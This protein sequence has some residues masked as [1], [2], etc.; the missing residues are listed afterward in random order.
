MAASW[1]EHLDLQQ[2]LTDR[3]RQLALPFFQVILLCP[4]LLHYHRVSLVDI[5][6]SSYSFIE[7]NTCA[8]HQKAKLAGTGWMG[9]PLLWHAC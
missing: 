9:R 7:S 6:K 5:L 2:W 3:V 4:G 1:R 8:I